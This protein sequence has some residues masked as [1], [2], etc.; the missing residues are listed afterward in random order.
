MNKLLLTVGLVAAIGNANVSSAAG[1]FMPWTGMMENIWRAY[2]KN[3]DGALAMAEVAEMDHLLGQDFGGF[4]PWMKDHFA[5]LDANHDGVVD[6]T[7]L[8]AMMLKMTWSDKNMVNGWY[9]NVGFMPLNAA[10]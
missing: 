9:K 7:E 2:D 5:D 1:G 4:M 10:Q 3:A 6:Q 8:H